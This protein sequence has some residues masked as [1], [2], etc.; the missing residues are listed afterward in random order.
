[1]WFLWGE[2]RLSWL[3]LGGVWSHFMKIWGEAKHFIKKVPQWGEVGICSKKWGV[4][5]F[6]KEMGYLM[7]QNWGLQSLKWGEVTY[8]W[9]QLW[10]EGRWN[11]N[12]NGEDTSRSRKMGGAYL[13]EGKNGGSILK[14]R[15]KWGEYT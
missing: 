4:R 2:W 6:S 8:I 13:G 1:M 15:K 5:Y 7:H 11:E 12:M 14:R 10:G 3:I 9:T